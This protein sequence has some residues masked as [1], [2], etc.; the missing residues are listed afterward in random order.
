[1]WTRKQQALK[2]PYLPNAADLATWEKELF[3]FY[4]NGSGG[5][6]G[7]S[8]AEEYISTERFNYDY[9][10]GFGEAIIKP[11]SVA[12]AAKHHLAPVKG[13]MKA[14]NAIM[15]LSAS[16]IKTH[17]AT[18]SAASLFALVTVPRPTEASPNREFDVL[19]GAPSEVSQ[20]NFDSPYYAGTV[21][22]FCGTMEHME[23]MTG[24]A[25]F[26]VPLPRKKEAF[27]GLTAAANVAV[28][29]RVVPLGGGA[30]VLKAA[31]V[32]SL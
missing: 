26:L 21:A 15:T 17:L 5:Q 7:P 13:L 6:V 31:S 28:N 18:D 12:L 11:P 19:V 30:S 10:P 20:V 9:Q 32:R 16:A 8:I 23:G 29:I 3:L 2:L 14:H 22:F 1:V 27:P 24:D 25:T 4:V